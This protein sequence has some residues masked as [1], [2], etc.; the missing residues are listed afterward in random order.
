M[1]TRHLMAQDA[2]N[3]FTSWRHKWLRMTESVVPRQP[4]AAHW[5][6]AHAPIPRRG[7]VMKL[8]SHHH[9]MIHIS[10]PNGRSQELCDAFGIPI[11][12]G[13]KR[14]AMIHIEKLF[15]TVFRNQ[16]EVDAYTTEGVTV[17]PG[18]LRIGFDPYPDE[19]H[20]PRWWRW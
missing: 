11:H 7:V 8:R 3:D 16:F 19:Q 13:S 1:M 17:A 14:D 9:H 15:S 12:F 5:L 4:G 18:Q 10:Y 6:F 2:A 20:V